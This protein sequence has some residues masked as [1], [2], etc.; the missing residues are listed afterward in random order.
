MRKNKDTKIK[1]IFNLNNGK[2]ICQNYFDITSKLRDIFSYFENNYSNKGYKLKKE[3]SFLN[4]KIRLYNRIS[5]LLFMQK[6]SN[7]NNN[8]EIY[9]EV[10]QQDINPNDNE[11]IYKTILFPKINP[12]ELI[13]YNPSESKIRYIKCPGQ[14]INFSFLYKFSKESSFCNSENE[15]YMSG[16]LYNG[17]TLNYFWIVEKKDFQIYKKTMPMFKKYHS[18]LYIP[19][20]F[21]LIAGGDSL[22][23]FIY[24]IENKTFIKWAYMNKK[25]FHPGL[26]LSGDYVYSFSSLYDKK[27][28]NYYFER[29]DLTSKNP[30]WEKINIIFP[31]FLGKK[32]EIFPLFFGISKNSREDIIFLGGEKNCN[33]Y[34]YNPIINKMYLSD[35]KN[36]EISF[37]DKTFYSINDKYRVGIPMNFPNEHILY[38]LNK[39]NENLTKVICSPKNDKD[40]LDILFDINSEEKNENEE[41]GIISIKINNE[42]INNKN[43]ENLIEKE[44][45]FMEDFSKKNDDTKMNKEHNKKDHLYLPSYILEEQ[46][47]NR[48]LMPDNIKESEF[49]IYEIPSK[50]KVEKD[51]TNKTEFKKSY[52]YIP[53]SIIADQIVERQVIGNNQE[54][55]KDNNEEILYIELNQKEKIDDNN[56]YKNNETFKKP[57]LKIIKIFYYIEMEYEHKKI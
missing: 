25:H 40:C 20:N 24:D 17:R 41:E 18:M 57:L 7:L 39:K 52:L 54:N 35:E 6:N 43:N 38:L 27:E 46:L 47:I 34:L 36:F 50:I 51:K 3:Y 33:R 4:K 19:D 16:G 49:T 28:E 22:T 30:K 23:T 29:S 42:D 11:E 15:L 26:I 2:I 21:V 37:W 12:F 44:I 1:V 9:I 45:I 32:N 48:E 56:N 10:I 53:N 31:D 14:S 8:S 13:E 5:D 55:K